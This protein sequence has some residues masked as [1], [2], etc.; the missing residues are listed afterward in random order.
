[1]AALMLAPFTSLFV[2]F[3]LVP[4]LSAVALGFFSFDMI[5]PPRFVGF[6]NYVRMLVD[7]SVFPIAV[8]NTLVFAFLT[9]PLG[10]VLSFLFAWL[11]NELRPRIRAWLT[12]LFYAPTLAGNV[13]FLWLFLFSGDAY[14]LVNS[15]LMQLGLIQ[16]PVQW[17]T[18]SRYSLGVVVLVMLWLS[19]GAGFLAIIAGF[20]GLSRE[21][22]EAAAVDGIRNRWQ[23]LWYVTLPQM[24]PQMLFAAVISIATSF[25]VGYQSMELTGFPSTDYATHTLTLHILDI[26]GIRFEMGYASALAFVLFAM[27]AVT[28]RGIETL[29]R[30]LAEGKGGK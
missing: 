9:G 7:D 8:R 3:T 21:L 1:M 23:E 29:F 30:R 13:F 5:N 16:E 15:T 27:M 28:W 26:G 11:I 20:Q 25:A 17:L 24:A 10:Y 2:L 18:D 22:Y 14:G 12:L 6:E 19:M 4:I